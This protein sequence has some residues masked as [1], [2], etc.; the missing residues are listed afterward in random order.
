MIKERTRSIRPMT[1]T[2]T[3]SHSFREEG[4]TSMRQAGTRTITTTPVFTLLATL[5]TTLVTDTATSVAQMDTISS[6]AINTTAK[7]TNKATIATITVTIAPTVAATLQTTATT[8]TTITTMERRRK[9][10]TRIQLAF[11]RAMVAAEASAC[12]ANP[13]TTTRPRKTC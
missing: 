1:N 4:C 10:T 3:A 7:A 6:R 9:V 5:I 12:S 2:F 11:S 13:T 8:I